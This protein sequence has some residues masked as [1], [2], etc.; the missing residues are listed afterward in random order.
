MNSRHK[1]KLL[2][3]LAALAISSIVI[4]LVLYALRQNIN[5][6][7]TPQQ[8]TARQIGNELRIRIGGFVRKDS[9]KYARDLTVNFIITDFT[10][11]V[12]VQYTGV[13]PDLFREEQGVVVLGKFKSDHIFYADQ[14]LAKHDENYRPPG[15]Q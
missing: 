5:L 4:G 8:L 2:Y 15:V 11:D 1:T 9:V 14:V 3:L 10:A 13:L 12:E 6:F 7:F